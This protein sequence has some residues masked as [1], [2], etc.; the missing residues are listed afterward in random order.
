MPTPLGCLTVENL[1]VPDYHYYQSMFL[2][3][4][5]DFFSL[6]NVRKLTNFSRIIMD[7]AFTKTNNPRIRVGELE[8]IYMF[9]KRNRIKTF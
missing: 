7:F 5:H 4:F 9:E 8:F 6:T 1:D 3:V 2:H